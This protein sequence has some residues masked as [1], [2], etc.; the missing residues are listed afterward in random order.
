[1]KKTISIVAVIIWTLIIFL[2]S[3]KTSAESNTTST[4]SY[5]LI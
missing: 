5:W 1:M 4:F 2:A 3:T